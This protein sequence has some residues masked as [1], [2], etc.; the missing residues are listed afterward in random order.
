V[1]AFLRFIGLM[2]A[3]VWL[4]GT[5]FFLFAIWP[6]TGSKEIE[7]LLGP[8]YFPFYSQAIGQTLLG[9]CFHFQIA[10][11]LI[12]LLHLLCEWLYFGRPSRKL[13]LTLLGILLALAV[14]G[15]NLVQ[16]RLQAAHKARFY[17]AEPASRESAARSFRVWH[18]LN[19]AFHLISIGG[20][21][22]YVWRVA[23]PSDT[24][25]FISSVKFRG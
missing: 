3:A 22:V 9:R 20:L 2:N 19:I 5:V 12:A 15:G 24:P 11:A 6:A 16:P 8:R 7:S 17:S 4:G 13:A 18:T 1:I 25:R 21:V 10:C 14:F 23:N